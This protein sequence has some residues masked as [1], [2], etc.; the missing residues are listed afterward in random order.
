MSIKAPSSATI[1]K[2]KYL[3]AEVMAFAKKQYNDENFEFL[4]AKDGNQALYTKYISED[5][6]RQVNLPSQLRVPLDTLAKQ[7]KWSAMTAGLKAARKEIEALANTQTMMDFAA[8]DHGQ[9]VLALWKMGLDS[10][11]KQAY[12]FLQVYENARTPEDGWKAFLA[13]V[14][15]AGESKAR[16]ALAEFGKPPPKTAPGGDAQQVARNLKIDAAAKKLAADIAAGLDYYESAINSVKREGLPAD[17][18]EVNRMFDSGRMR[19]E[20]AHLAWNK[21]ILADRDF[22]KKYAQVARDKQKLDTQWAA[23]RQAIAAAEKKRGR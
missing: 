15:L 4:F 19:H 18:H 10:K 16:A 6:A 1:N 22:V 8:S 17:D 14:K 2:N 3:Y 20:K 23:Y 21:L 5:G 9:R 7:K 12:P 13:L 11:A